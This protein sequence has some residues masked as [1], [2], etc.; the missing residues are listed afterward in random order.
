MINDTMIRWTKDKNVKE[1]PNSN[2][3]PYRS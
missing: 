3:N 1:A 2:S